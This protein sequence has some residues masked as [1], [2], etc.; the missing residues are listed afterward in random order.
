MT[1]TL[2]SSP[3]NKKIIYSP[4]SS[5]KNVNSPLSKKEI[6]F[7]SNHCSES[8]VDKGPSSECDTASC[9]NKISHSVS[10]TFLQSS[11][12]EDFAQA[13][14]KNSS[15]WSKNTSEPKLPVSDK[16]VVGKHIE[17]IKSLDKVE[18]C[19]DALDLNSKSVEVNPTVLKVEPVLSNEIMHYAEKPDFATQA[20]NQNVN[21]TPS[22]ILTTKNKSLIPVNL[23][24]TG[25]YNLLVLL[26]I[27]GLFFT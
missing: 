1:N 12:L 27:S 17:D 22:N 4:G 10:D 7:K 3:L 25:M 2:K 13:N 15:K 16:T 18:D 20:V 11:V 26:N 24:N 8:F 23:V 6:E 19:K 5:V 14:T 21:N 9:Q